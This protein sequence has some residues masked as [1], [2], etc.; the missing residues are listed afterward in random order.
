MDNQ[1]RAQRK[2]TEASHQLRSLRDAI[3]RLAIIIKE[4]DGDV[5][6]LVSLSETSIGSRDVTIEYFE[7]LSTRIERIERALQLL[8]ARRAYV[9]DEER[10]IHSDL[11]LQ[12]RKS[13]L[14]KQLRQY[15]R[16]LSRLQEQ[17]A[18]F[19]GPPLPTSLQN[20]IEDTKGKIATI[21]E[22]LKQ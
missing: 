19:G 10:A 17:R 20:E 13:S 3:E 6:L 1:D 22:E 5:T 14:K 12:G 21:Q 4:I 11:E 8:L 7:D 9:E 18:K 16:N 2:R 15:S